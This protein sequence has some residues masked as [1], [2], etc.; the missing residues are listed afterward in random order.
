MPIQCSARGV[1]VIPFSV[2]KAP[3]ARE[4]RVALCMALLSPASFFAPKYCEITMVAPE[5]RPMKKPISRF[6]ICAAERYRS[7]GFLAHIIADYYCIRRVIQL[8]EKVPPRMGKKSL[9]SCRQIPPCVRSCP[10]IKLCLLSHSKASPD[11]IV[12]FDF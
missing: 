12:I 9:S 1:N 5:A 7:K 3:P 4:N 11:I 8:L 10:F 6:T 2:R